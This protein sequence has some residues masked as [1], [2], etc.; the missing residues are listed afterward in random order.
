MT[1]WI[2]SPS[3]RASDSRLST[4]M[5][6]PQPTTVPWPAAS[7]VRQW[8]SGENL[9]SSLKKE[10]LL[11]VNRLGVARAE[12]EEVRVEQVDVVDHTPG[13]D[14]TGEARSRLVDADRLHFLRGEGRD[15]LDAVA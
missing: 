8:P 13:F 14:V 3:A 6:T 11:G 4:T 9:P 2:V 10:A 12:P 5:P 1:A 7:K 15:G